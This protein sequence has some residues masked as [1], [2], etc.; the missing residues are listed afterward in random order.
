M[1]D[2]TK[3]W[4]PVHQEP[5]TEHRYPRQPDVNLFFDHS[6]ALHGVS[7]AHGLDRAYRLGNRLGMSEPTT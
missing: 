1:I 4:I 2:H 6:V 5:F 7:V 3:I